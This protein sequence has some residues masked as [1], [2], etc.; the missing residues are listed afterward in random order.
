LHS[1]RGIRGEDTHG[2]ACWFVGGYCFRRRIDSLVGRLLMWLREFGD[3][4][5][6]SGPDF[7]KSGVGNEHGCE[8]VSHVD[9][10]RHCRGAGRW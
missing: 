9:L 4:V 8:D 7:E 2:D 10:S 5:E 1:G 3:D 6:P